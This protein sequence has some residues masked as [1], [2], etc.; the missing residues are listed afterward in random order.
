M[1]NRTLKS[2]IYLTIACAV[3]LSSEV[4]AKGDLPSPPSPVNVADMAPS[5][6]KM[7]PAA[8]PAGSHVTF[9]GSNLSAVTAVVFNSYHAKFRVVNDT[10]IVA[11][12]PAGADSGPVELET[13]TGVIHSVSLFSVVAN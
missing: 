9:T 10:T 13:P 8:G 6:A 1:T 7:T 3:L 5:I 2:S 12:V 11:T 4:L